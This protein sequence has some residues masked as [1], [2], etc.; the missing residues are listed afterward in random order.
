M[1][2]VEEKQREL[3]YLDKVDFF[4]NNFDF[5]RF[6]AATMVIVG[7]T[8]PL[9]GSNFDPLSKIT[10]TVSLGPLGLFIFF[11]IS[12]FL[13]TK[14]WLDKPNFFDFFKKRLLRIMPGL[15]LATLFGFLVIGPLATS[16]STKEYFKNS[17]SFE[18]LKNIFFMTRVGI[19]SVFENN[20]YSAAINGSLWSLPV[21]FWMYIAV[22]VLGLIGIL[23]RAKL[24][25]PFV[26]L[27]ILAMNWHVLVRPEYKG[28]VV[29]GISAV[30]FFRLGLFFALGS[31][32]YLY[33]RLV[34]LDIKLVIFALAILVLTFHTTLSD[35]ALTFIL[36]YVVLAFA[37]IP[38]ARFLRKWGKFGDFSYGMYVYAFPVQQTIIHFLKDKINM[39]EFFCLA[40]IVTLILSYGSWHLVEKQALKLK[41][42]PII[43][44]IVDGLRKAFRKVVPGSSL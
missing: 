12:G 15:I 31:A 4:D 29:L 3:T 43:K 18:Y 34:I 11:I 44:P 36:P 32:F 9:F 38:K 42:K 23:K 28:M 33:R 1:A 2:K 5:L 19:P 16:L 27:V 10:E 24:F 39:F 14:S 8:F 41:K 25:V 37:Y 22:A 20:P 13:I 21:E 6:L 30:Q 40:F 26:I 17:S 7:H 35:L